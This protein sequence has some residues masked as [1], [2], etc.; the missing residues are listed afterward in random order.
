MED[1]LQE[2]K[3]FEWQ[4]RHGKN[5][6]TFPL[7]LLN[8]TN[9]TYCCVL[10]TVIQMILEQ[11]ECKRRTKFNKDMLYQITLNEIG[12]RVCMTKSTIAMAI[13]TL[14][15]LGFITRKG[16]KKGRNGYTQIQINISKI[17]EE[18]RRNTKY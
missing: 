13:T 15:E 2:L 5:I 1:K 10:M 17:K 16:C 7:A 14:E 9:P 6:I 11:L 3:E 12:E 8:V 4:M 18:I